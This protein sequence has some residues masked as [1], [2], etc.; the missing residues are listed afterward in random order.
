LINSKVVKNLDASFCKVDEEVL[1]KRL[2][3][4]NKLEANNKAPGSRLPGCGLLL[5]QQTR[6]QEV[7]FKQALVGAARKK[8]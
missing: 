4:R 3:K 5:L 1:E 2:H 8:G 7:K 6:Q